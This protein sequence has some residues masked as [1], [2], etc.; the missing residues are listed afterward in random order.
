M[1]EHF[2][3]CLQYGKLHLGILVAGSGSLLGLGQSAF[4][5]LEVLELQ[6]GVDDL[7]VAD[8]VDGAVDVGDVVVVEAAE[9]VDDGVGLADVAQELIAQALALRGPLHQAG[10]VY[11]LA[12][13][14]Y[15]APGVDEL[16][17]ACEPLVG[18]GDHAHVGLNGA[19]RKVG[20]LRLGA[21]QTVEQC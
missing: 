18:D 2:L 21:R 16:G 17:Q 9:H 10:Y 1:V 19:K 11:Y 4:D 5:G 3:V 14:G 15:D 6:L 8:G 13:G 20:C 12:R 7:L